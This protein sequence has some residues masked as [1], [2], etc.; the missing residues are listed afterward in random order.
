[1]IKQIRNDIKTA[2][3][4]KDVIRRDVLKMVLNKANSIAKESKIEEAT[5]E[6]V[7]D[8]IKKESKQL[9]DTI[10]ILVKN[11]KQDSE[12]Y[13]ESTTKI[14]LLK[15]YLPKQLTED[16]LIVQIQLFIE[17]NNIDTSNRGAIMKAVMPEFKTK[18]D[19]KMINQIVG[20][21][22]S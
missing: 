18:A 11:S 3:I 8:A 13:A 5:N 9:Q 4:E 1:M 12:L 19:G 7:F 17:N 21:L 15:T 6:M 22:F 20:K 10:D 2:M 16:E 14:N